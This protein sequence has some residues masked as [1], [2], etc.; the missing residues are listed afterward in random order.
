MN[1]RGRGRGR[2]S[3]SKSP[4]D[5]QKNQKKTSDKKNV[6]NKVGY[7]LGKGDK[8]V[9]NPD[10]EKDFVAFALIDSAHHD[11]SDF[12]RIDKIESKIQELELIIKFAQNEVNKKAIQG[13]INKWQLQ[14]K[15]K[16]IN[17][18]N[19]SF[20]KEIVYIVD[21]EFETM[22]VDK[23]TNENIQS[24][25]KVS[26]KETI[27]KEGE[28]SNNEIPLK[29]KTNNEGLH[30]NTAKSNEECSV[31]TQDVITPKTKPTMAEVLKSNDVKQT[32]IPSH[33]SIRVRLSLRSQIGARNDTNV[34]TEI[35][36]ILIRILEIGRRV[37]NRMKLL[38]WT[39]QGL[40]TVEPINRDGAANITFDKLRNYIHMPNGHTALINNKMCHGLG[41]NISTTDDV[42]TFINKWNQVKFKFNINK[43]KGWISLK[44]SE[45]QRYHKAFPVGFF[46][47]SSE[48]GVYEILNKELPKIV[49]TNIEVSFQNIYQ[50][51]V[52]G[53]F[54]EFAKN[55]AL[56]QGNEGSKDF[57]SRKFSLAPSGLIAYVYREADIN[58][59]FKNLVKHYGKQ[60][61]EKA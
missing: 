60:T 26:S 12:K 23:K 28:L 25:E 50:R 8:W 46:Q 61:A 30:V 27:R 35:R 59:A 17:K 45:V 29:N 40:S 18:K 36:R 57:R 31:I 53:K 4:T 11:N 24:M 34:A 58:K 56:K 19:E 54:W 3:P 41:V 6:K 55:E 38:P 33:G 44:Q 22:D 16:L 14:L 49:G 15:E 47:G 20:E 48:T 42:N 52:T 13:I 39:I 1:A 21:D 51:G 43:D 5:R 32:L 2:S 10:I 9:G 7:K 37:D